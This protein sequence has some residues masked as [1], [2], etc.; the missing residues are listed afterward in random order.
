[1]GGV[2]SISK[3]GSGFNYAVNSYKDCY[4]SILPFFI[5]HAIHSVAFKSHNFK[6]WKEV[7]NIMHSGEHKNEAGQ[8]QIKKMLLKLKKYKHFRVLLELLRCLNMCSAQ[9]FFIS[10]N[11]LIYLHDL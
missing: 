8:L 3:N 5:E 7:L 1:L 10:G 9:I 6:V 4:N 2:G 11:Q